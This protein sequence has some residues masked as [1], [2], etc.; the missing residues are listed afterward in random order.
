M[1]A[2]KA[3][4]DWFDKHHRQLSF[5]QNRQAYPI[6][7]SEIMAQQ[8]RIDTMLPYFER[9]MKELP[10]VADLAKV[11]DEKLMKLWEGLGYYSRARNLK[12]AA[13]LC[14]DGFPTTYEGWLALP[15]VGPYTAG[16]VA[17]IVYGL[18]VP[19]IDGNVLRV[20][21]RYQAIQENVLDKAVHA[22]IADVVKKWLDFRPGDVNQALMELGALVC[23]P[24]NPQCHACPLQPGCQAYEKGLTETLPIRLKAL[25]RKIEKKHF[26][27]WANDK[28]LRLVKREQGLLAGLYGF[29]E[30]WPEKVVS[31]IKLVEYQHVFTHITWKIEASLVICEDDFEPTRFDEVKNLAVATAFRPIIEALERIEDGKSRD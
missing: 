30:S 20:I 29:D 14:V 27:V 28:G 19:A 13:Q 12:K 31:K 7:V 8:T 25:K 9:F 22:R 5:R 10:T 6:W 21:S 18:A 1:S 23:T 17:S 26:V 2:S 3:L 15:G 24:K 11:E 16:A 4:L